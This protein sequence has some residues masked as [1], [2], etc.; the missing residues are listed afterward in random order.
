MGS[1]GKVKEVINNYCRTIWGPGVIGTNEAMGREQGRNGVAMCEAPGTAAV[2]TKGKEGD[3]TP[4]G[5]FHASFWKVLGG[6]E[7][8]VKERPG[9]PVVIIRSP[10]LCQLHGREPGECPGHRAREQ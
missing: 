8:G 1:L 2:S 3:Q 9:I 10:A 4:Q 6:R 7:V 5:P